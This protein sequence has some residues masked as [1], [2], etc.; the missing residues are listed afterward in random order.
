[1]KYAILDESR[2]I[3]NIIEV[4]PEYAADFD[5]HYLGDA[6][7]GIGDRYPDEDLQPPPVYDETQSLGQQIT[8]EQ[9]ERIEMGQAYTDLEL[10]LLEQG[11]KITDV[12]LEALK[13][14]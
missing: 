8:D 5:A 4:E 1:M 13:N 10:A 11:Q 2:T 9:L 7:I 12:E 3:T 6:P 14:V